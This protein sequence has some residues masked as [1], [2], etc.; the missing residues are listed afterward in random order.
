MVTNQETG[1]FN[2]CDLPF[3]SED[4][5]VFFFEMKSYKKLGGVQF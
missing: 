1:F 3:R 2:R 5:T 4:G